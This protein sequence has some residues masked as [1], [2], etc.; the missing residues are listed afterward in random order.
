MGGNKILCVG[1]VCLDVVT[2][3]NQYPDEGTDQ[4][5][6]EMYMQKGGN[7]ANTA[8][9][10]SLLGNEVDFFGCIPKN[11]RNL[12]SKQGLD[13]VMNEMASFGVG[14]EYAVKKE[15]AELPISNVIINESNGSRTIMAKQKIT[16]VSYDDFLEIDIKEYCWIHFEGRN[17]YDLQK[18]VTRVQGYNTTKPISERIV[19]SVEFEKP[20]RANL[21][22]LLPHVNLVFVSEEFAR[23]KGFE[24]AISCVEEFKKETKKGTHV[25]CAWGSDGAASVTAGSSRGAVMTPAVPPPEKV[26]RDTLGAGDTFNATVINHLCRVISQKEKISVSASVKYGCELAGYKVGHY[27]YKCMK[28]FCNRS[29]SSISAI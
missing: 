8:A 6:K 1:L 27:G 22:Q 10:L 21:L 4:K 15:N 23:N 11:E 26:V 2:V 19:V 5:V 29:P 16:E 17:L 28:K 14:M 13:V 9:V 18:M 3:C 20:R 25:I 24:S 12:F 7:A